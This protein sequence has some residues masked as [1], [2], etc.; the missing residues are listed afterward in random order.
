[1]RTLEI[2]F[3][4]YI[5]NYWVCTRF[6]HKLFEKCAQFNRVLTAIIRTVCRV[7]KLLEDLFWN[8]AIRQK[9]QVGR[10]SGMGD[11]VCFLRFSQKA[12]LICPWHSYQFSGVVQIF[13]VVVSMFDVTIR[14]LN[15]SAIEYVTSVCFLTFLSIGV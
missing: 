10:Y 13:K 15:S 2:T 8:S 9:T 12:K 6:L 7:Q 11:Q 5:P 1:M 4:K 14:P 3:R